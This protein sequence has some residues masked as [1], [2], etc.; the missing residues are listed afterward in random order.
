M[1]TTGSLTPQRVEIWKEHWQDEGDAAYLYRR[2]AT[3]E[4]DQDRARLFSDLADVEDRHQAR[5]RDL[6]HDAGVEMRAHRPSPR[7]RLQTVMGRIF[8]WKTLVSLLLAEE[9]RETKT[10]L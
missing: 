1:A 2:M 10:Y 4:P 5:W 8:G 6:L 9:G 3:V 7:A